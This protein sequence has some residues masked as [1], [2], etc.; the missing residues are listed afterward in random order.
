MRDL[1]ADSLNGVILVFLISSMLTLG[2]SVTVRQI[3]V[4]LSDARLVI[5]SLATNYVL[6]PLIA[7]VVTRIIPLDEALR[8]GFVLYALAAGSEAGPRFVETGKGN[9][10]LAVGLLVLFLAV[11]IVYVPMILAVALPEAHIDR[12]KLLTKLVVLVALPT[13]VGLFLK[14]RHAAITARLRPGADRLSTVFMWLLLALVLL[15]NVADLS[16]LL[17]SGGLLAAA[18]FFTLAFAA[19]YLTGGRERSDRRTLGI[20]TFARNASLTLVIAGQVFADRP[21]ALVM[22]IAMAV[23]SMLIAVPVASWLGRRGT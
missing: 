22:I 11:N 21:G 4:P 12:V 6:V 15:L 1:L 14:A 3:L 20:M 8:S 13:G 2:L 10:A 9:V 16:R 23:V 5:S 18:L 7:I 19:G 17:G